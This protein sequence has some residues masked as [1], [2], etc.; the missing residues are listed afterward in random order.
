MRTMINGISTYTRL[1][2]NKNFKPCNINQIIA[3]IQQD[4]NQA[5]KEN[6]ASIKVAPLPTIKCNATAIRQIFQNLI[7]NA[8]KFHQPNTPPVVQIT[9]REQATH[10]EFC[11]ADNGIGI[12]KHKLDAVFQMFTK[13]HLPTEFEG[14]G[15]GLAFCK[16]IIELHQGDIWIESTPNAGSQFYFSIFKEL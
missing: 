4:L 11:V 9:C 12:H 1:G 2:K 10:W 13:L 8:I 15:I 5:I 6:N 16:K 3:G 14:H 7:A